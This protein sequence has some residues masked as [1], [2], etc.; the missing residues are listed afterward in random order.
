MHD[1][2]TLLQRCEVSTVDATHAMLERVE[3][4]AQTR[5][6]GATASSL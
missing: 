5:N 2:A 3:L 6:L 1:V 4:F